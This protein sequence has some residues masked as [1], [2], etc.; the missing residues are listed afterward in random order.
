ML[1]GHEFNAAEYLKH[2]CILSFFFSKT[3]QTYCTY[4][5]IFC[6]SMNRLASLPSFELYALPKRPKDLR[7]QNVEVEIMVFINFNYMGR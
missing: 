3:P 4:L 5:I 7:F 6:I 1:K 2:A